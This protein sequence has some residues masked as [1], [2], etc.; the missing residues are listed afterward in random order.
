MACPNRSIDVIRPSRSPAVIPDLELKPG[1]DLAKIVE[2]GENGEPG[3]VDVV[4]TVSSYGP[5]EPLSQNRLLDQSLEAARHIRTM[6]LEAM[7]STRVVLPPRQTR[8]VHRIMT[9]G[10]L[11]CRPTTRT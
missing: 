11:M 6:V 1:A 3:E 4:Q 8:Y 9:P 2:K 5:V 7:C 10:N